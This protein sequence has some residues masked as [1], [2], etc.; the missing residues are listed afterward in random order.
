M[1]NITEDLAFEAL[2]HDEF[3][4]IKAQIDALGEEPIGKRLE[5]EI[6]DISPIGVATIEFSESY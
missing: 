1:I 3:A 6:V 5:A 2:F 4:E